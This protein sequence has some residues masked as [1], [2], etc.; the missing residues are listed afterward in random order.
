MG[1]QAGLASWGAAAAGLLIVA[2]WR[3]GSVAGGEIPDNRKFG[4]ILN[5]DINNILYAVSGAQTTPTEYKKAVMHLLDAKPGVLAQNVGVPDP[6]I[7][8]SEVATTWDKYLGGDQ[9][10]AMGAL[11]AAGTDPLAITIEA[12]R[13][14]GILIV[15][16]YRMNAED[17]YARQLDLYDFGRAHK[18]LRIP[19]ANCLDP[20][21]PEV[22]EHRMAI[23]REVAENCDIDGIEFD[24]RRWTHMISDPLENH[25][26]LTRMVRET[27]EMLD[28]IAEKKGRGRMILGARVGPT[29]D[30]E[31]LGP[32]EM[33]CRALGLD[34]TTW[35]KEGLVDYLCP[36]FFW[37]HNPGDD[38]KTAEFVTLAKGTNVGI[39]PTVFP[40]SKWQKESAE[41]ERID[42]DETEDLRRY[43]DDIVGAALKC[44]AEGAGGISTFNWVPHQQPGMTRRNIRESW[45]LGAAKVQM[46]IHPLLKDRKALEAAL[47]SDVVLPED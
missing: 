43:R 37:G 30:G 28:E 24:F 2:C 27:R 18:D 40:Y 9:A 26:V 36:T 35:V 45:G 22:F 34:V 14:H 25:P 8:R 32:N 3:G 46:L 7:Y 19:G 20:V 10:G 13:E 15:A 1:C 44:Y 11:L 29:I 33:S 38:P 31:P 42:P 5:N 39:Y 47:K 12:C 4:S 17:F 41:A 23:F 21:H 16:S 6:V